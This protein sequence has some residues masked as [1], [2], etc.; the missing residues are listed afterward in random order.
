MNF[1]KFLPFLLIVLCS[2]CTRVKDPEFRRIEKFRLINIGLQEATIG[3][4]VTYFNPNN[5]GVAVRQAEADIYLDSLYLGK[6]VQDSSISV[7][8]NAEFSLPLS[9]TVSL[10][11]VLKLNLQELSEREILVRAD[12]NVRVGKTGIFVTRPIHYQGMH[13]L[14][15]MDLTK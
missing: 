6:F 13:R 3:F 7:A 2:S 4:S 12:G 11:T 10:Q 8:K 9:G 15:D 1:R 14:E 5:F